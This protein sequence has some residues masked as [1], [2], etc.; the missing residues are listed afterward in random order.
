MKVLL[1]GVGRWGEKHL[2]VLRELGA[3]VWVAT[4]SAERQAWAVGHGVSGARIVADYREALALV[5]AVDVVTAADTHVPIVTTCLE[6]GRHVFVEKPLATTV[7]EGRALAATASRTGRVLQVGHIYRFHPV[8]TAL[9]AALA[10]G[11]I[12][13]VRFA[14][15]RFGGFK[16]PRPDTGVTLSDA[17]HWFDLFAYVLERPAT[18]VMSVQRDHLGRGLDDFS[19][20]VVQYGD[21][22]VTVEA[23][24]FTPGTHRSCTIVGEDGRLAAD[25]TTSRL[26][27]HT[28]AHR[29]TGSEWRADAGAAEDLPVGD[30]EALRLQLAAF[31]DAC[32]GRAPVAVTAAAGV[33]AL[34]IAEAAAQASRLQREVKVPLER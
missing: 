2:R 24:Y 30:A 28:G 27:L 11:R 13:R 4:R 16:R 32:T 10:A 23:E 3:D 5:D 8:T 12:G 26:T 19:L 6:R 1:V 25:Y 21:V 29:A 18:A 33:H 31:L 34:E 7:A 20:S 17:I 9:R 22:P 14:S 15:G